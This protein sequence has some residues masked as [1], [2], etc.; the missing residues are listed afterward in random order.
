MARIRTVKPEFFR[1]EELQ[2][3]E[4]DHPNQACMLV[5]CGLWTQADREG[6]FRWLPR[7]LKLDILPFIPFD[8]AV[9]MDLLESIG[10]LQKYTV[11]DKTYGQVTNWLRH[12][13]PGRDEPPSELPGPEGTFTH[14]DLPPNATV[15]ARLYERDGYLCVYC[16][17]DLRKDTRAI[18]LDHVIPYSKQGTNRD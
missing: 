4:N 8:M 18:C 15:R 3:L 1:D 12:Q 9:T 2:Q 5:F 6:R 10:C 17:R 13:I 7:T 16:N 11:S 14:Y